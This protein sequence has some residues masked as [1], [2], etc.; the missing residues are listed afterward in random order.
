M[1]K[2]RLMETVFP[3]FLHVDGS[4]LL[5]YVKV[6]LV[7]Y[8][9]LGSQFLSFNV[10]NVLLCFLLDKAVLLESLI[11]DSL[12]SFP[13]NHVVCCLDACSESVFSGV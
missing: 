3:K 9:I 1:S 6:S 8:E 7:K 4:L 10:L 11:D 13:R 5:L 12:L 2:E